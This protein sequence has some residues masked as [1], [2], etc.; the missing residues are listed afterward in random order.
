MMGVSEIETNECCICSRKFLSTPSKEEY[1][2]CCSSDCL[3]IY[4]WIETLDFM[5][6]LGME[7]IMEYIRFD[8]A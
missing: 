7:Y 8:D 2:Y 5:G 3:S 6:G 4:F 1:S